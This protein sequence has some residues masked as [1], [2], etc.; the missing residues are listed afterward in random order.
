VNPNPNP[1]ERVFDFRYQ[2]IYLVAQVS[3]FIDQ[4][5]TQDVISGGKVLVNGGSRQTGSFSQRR[6]RYGLHAL[7]CNEFSG[8]AKY[9]LLARIKG[10][11]S[12]F[13]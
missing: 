5:L 6:H 4:Q 12:H 13:P 10:L 9:R 3:H 2:T 11:R 7:D 1:F 8:C